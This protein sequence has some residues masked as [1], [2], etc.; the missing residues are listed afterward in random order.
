MKLYYSS[1]TERKGS[2]QNSDGYFLSDSKQK[3]HAKIS[4]MPI[5]EEHV[6]WEY[7]EIESFQTSD[8]KYAIF[9]KYAKN[10]LLRI[11]DFELKKYK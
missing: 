11:D 6:S 9:C 2:W 10:G 1:I 7:S 4:V 3:L 8:E 5:H